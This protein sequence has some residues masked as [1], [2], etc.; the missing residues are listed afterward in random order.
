ME[1]KDEWI[2]YTEIDW[3]DPE[4]NRFNIDTRDFHT[5]YTLSTEKH[6]DWNRLKS[7]PDFLHTEDEIKTLINRLYLESGG[8]G[9][10]RMIELKSTDKRVLYWRLKYLRIYREDNVFLVCNTDDVAIPKNIL[11]NSVNKEYLHFH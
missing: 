7:I 6:K 9:K 4:N 11:K 3:L 2:K 8:K 1:E 5:G 10:W